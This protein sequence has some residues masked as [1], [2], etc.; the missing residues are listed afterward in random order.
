ETVLHQT[1]ATGKKPRRVT[2]ARH[3]TAPTVREVRPAS[4]TAG[5]AARG[6]GR[7]ARDR[8]VEAVSTRDTWVADVRRVRSMQIREGHQDMEIYLPG[9]TNRSLIVLLR[10]VI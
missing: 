6:S 4:G 7:R 3:E 2:P 10:R 9:A 5:R 8:G 1:D